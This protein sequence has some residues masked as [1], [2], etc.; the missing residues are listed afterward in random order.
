ME[1]KEDKSF[2]TIPIIVTE[3]KEIV[4]NFL[5]LKI[6]KLIIIFILFF[7]II[8]SFSFWYVVKYHVY[9]LQSINIK[10]SVLVVTTSDTSGDKPVSLSDIHTDYASS[11]NSSQ[12]KANI[13][14]V[15][16]HEP[17][18]GGAQFRNI[19][20]RNL[21]AE[22]GQDLQQFLQTNPRYKVSIT[23]DSKSWSTTFDDY[24][25]NNWNDIIRWEKISKQNISKIISIGE[26]SV[27][28][29]THNT[30]P[31][32]VA[33]RLYGITKWVN[34]NNIDLMIHLHFNDYPERVT[35]A[36]GKYS[37]LVI[38]TPAL[39]YANSPTTK[40][41]AD[42]IFKRLSLYN[43]I[44][45]LPLESKGIIDDPEL[46]AVGANN[47]SNAASVLIEYDY[48]YE[49]QYINTKVRSLALRDLAYQTYLGLQDFFNKNKDIN[50]TS[51][52]NP[53]SLYSWTIPVTG[54][55][56]NPEDIYALQTA[57]IMDGSFPPVGKNKNQCPHSGA[58]D[59]CTNTA[60]KEFQKKYAILGESLSGTKTFT[61]L[62]NIY[63]KIKIN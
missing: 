23:R 60:L 28:T 30:A 19:Y 39:Q 34:E 56:S 15:P 36:V 53:S 13:L 2:N 45:N 58:Y 10:N 4:N 49:P 50:V 55:S 35:Y 33:T 44:S 48:I 42:T 41:I 3:K 18:F 57:L 51:S 54:K 20:E 24:F 5:E 21:V 7:S 29:I 22:V 52:Y 32:N 8:I 26:S 46:I 25:K 43:P 62:S 6:V 61:L 9:P 59:T 47:T 63:A 16:G 11:S 37:G 17:N 12:E 1:I 27:P 14:I 31:L 38:Y 40:D